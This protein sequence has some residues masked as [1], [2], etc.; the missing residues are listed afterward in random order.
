MLTF[1]NYTDLILEIPDT[2]Q[3]QSR[4]HSQYFSNSYSRYQAY[5]NELYLSLV[6]QWLQEHL[7]PQVKVWLTTAS[8]SSFWELVNATALIRDSIKLI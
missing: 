6:L 1:T 2:I 7:T 4:L 3:Q 5:I 8:V